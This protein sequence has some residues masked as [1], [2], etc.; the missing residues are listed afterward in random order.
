[1][2]DHYVKL[3]LYGIYKYQ[4]HINRTHLMVYSLCQISYESMEDSG[5]LGYDAGSPGSRISTFRRNVL[6]VSSTIKMS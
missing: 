2:F 5:L 3:Q 1:M 6:S 4:I